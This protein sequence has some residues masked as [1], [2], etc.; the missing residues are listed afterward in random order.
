MNDSD[1]EASSAP[2]TISPASSPKPRRRRRVRVVSAAAIALGLAVGGGAVANAASTPSASNSSSPTAGPGRPPFPGGS[3]PAAMGTVAS[4]G[5]NTFTITTKDDTTVTV[6]VSSTTTYRD[7]GE[8]SPTLADVTVG[9]HVAVFGTE[10]SD[11][12]TAASVA[13]GN[14]PGGGG[15][16]VPGE[17]P[18]GSPP[19]AMGT[20]ASV[21]SNTF[22]ITTK[23]DTTVTVNVSS[24]TT[25]RDAGESSPTLADVTVGQHVAVFGTETSDV[26]TAASVAIGNPPGGGGKGGPGGFPGGPPPAG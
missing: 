24:T 16:G 12:V 11:V 3:P 6:N 20:V 25:Y 15:K 17:F 23:D 5:S 8:S 4:V 2:T 19:A 21:G 18:G 10:T 1:V 9:Q 13:I 22:T 14:P 7:A 26:V